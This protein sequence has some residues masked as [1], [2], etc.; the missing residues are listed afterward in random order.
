[1]NV[2]AY[3]ITLDDLASPELRS[4]AYNRKKDKPLM[5]ELDEEGEKK[6]EAPEPDPVRD[7]AIRIINDLIELTTGPKT[8]KIK[9]ESPAANP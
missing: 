1:M 2:A 4:V 9:S 3:E 8:V 5:E 7:E 6:D